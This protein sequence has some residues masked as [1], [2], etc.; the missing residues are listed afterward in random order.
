MLVKISSCFD[1]QE[2]LSQMRDL[3]RA[4]W[5]AQRLRGVISAAPPRAPVPGSG[6]MH[7]PKTLPRQT[8]KEP[9]AAYLATGVHERAQEEVPLASRVTKWFLASIQEPTCARD[10]QC[11]FEISTICTLVLGA[12][13]FLARTTS[14]MLPSTAGQQC[15]EA[16]EETPF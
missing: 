10:A 14:K 16:A 9:R 13:S 2:T 3:G 15:G 5:V 1:H 11:D 6:W 4:S 7:L 12:L 8:R